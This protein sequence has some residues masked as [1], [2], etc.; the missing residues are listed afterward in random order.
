VWLRRFQRIHD[1]T[2][3]RSRRGTPGHGRRRERPAPVLRSRVT[4]FRLF[5]LLVL[6]AVALAMLG[7]GPY[8]AVAIGMI[9][10]AGV[11]LARPGADREV[12]V[13]LLWV[14]AMAAVAVAIV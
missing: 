8:R 10:T 7:I 14:L 1:S 5:V 4:V 6:A 3:P 11:A 12:R 9:G 2:V 13:A